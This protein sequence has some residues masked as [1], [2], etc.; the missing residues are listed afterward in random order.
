MF[1]GKRQAICSG[2][3]YMENLTGSIPLKALNP[4]CATFAMRKHLISIRPLTLIATEETPNEVWKLASQN[5]ADF[6]EEDRFATFLGFQYQGEPG[7][8]GVRDC[9]YERQQ[10]FADGKKTAKSSSLTKIY[11]SISL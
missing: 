3:F 4:V 11:K 1:P 7:K 10:S 6:N 5:I 8:E 9:L 2:V